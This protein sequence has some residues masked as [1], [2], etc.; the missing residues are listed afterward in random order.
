MLLPSS[1]QKMTDAN[2]NFGSFASLLDSTPHSNVANPYQAAKR[3]HLLEQQR[4]EEQ[5]GGS[6]SA[7][8]RA[9]GGTSGQ[10]KEGETNMVTPLN[11]HTSPTKEFLHFSVNQN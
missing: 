6:D 2:Q 8:K 9:V 10:K 5:L 4:Q 11:M 7:F 3:R 1:G